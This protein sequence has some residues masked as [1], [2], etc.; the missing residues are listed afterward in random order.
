MQDHLLGNKAYDILKWVA[1]IALPAFGALYYTIAGIWGL[2][3][4]SE[5]VGTVT[6][7]DTCLGL[8]LG[9]STKSYN[10]SEAKYDGTIDVLNR[11]DGPPLA[12]LNLKNYENPAD[13]V[14]Q[15]QVLFKVNES[16]S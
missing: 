6:A 7:V 8:L 11:E 1:L 2:P 4:A 16:N 13:V 15:K 14:K 10:N 3:N 12:S 9:L 5:V